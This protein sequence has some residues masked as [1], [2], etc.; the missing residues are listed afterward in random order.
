MVIGIEV[1]H[2]VLLHRGFTR[3]IGRFYDRFPRRRRYG[4]RGLL[5]ALQ[6]DSGIVSDAFSWDY[7][8]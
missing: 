2:Y 7:F 1:I 3:S 4:I 8:S 5:E 6:K